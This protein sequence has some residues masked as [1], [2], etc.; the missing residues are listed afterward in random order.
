MT[1]TDS[2]KRPDVEVV[3]ATVVDGTLAAGDVADTPVPWWSFTK[4]VLAAAALVLVDAE[5]LTLDAPLAADAIRCA[6]CCSIVRACPITGPSTPIM[7]LWRVVG[8]PGRSASCSHRYIRKRPG[9]SPV[10]VGCIRM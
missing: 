2:T 5:R 9:S 10:R 4:T 7:T 1:R 3:T 8:R 6:S